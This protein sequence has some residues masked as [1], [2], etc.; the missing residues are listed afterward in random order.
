[1][2]LL[3]DAALKAGL[4]SLGGM[5]NM[6]NAAAQA[7]SF[8]NMKGG[9]TDAQKK[10]KAGKEMARLKALAHAALATGRDKVNAGDN[11]T[12]NSNF[13]NAYQV[14]CV[15]DWLWKHAMGNS[16][17]SGHAGYL[18]L[19]RNFSKLAAG[20]ALPASCANKKCKKCKACITS[21][22]AAIHD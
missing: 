4:A 21:E 1:M 18:T 10:A 12:A 8:E 9:T 14:R 6:F 20:A 11:K 22:I 7:K 5:Y 15:C 13:A 16:G 3:T 19:S 17:D 2:P